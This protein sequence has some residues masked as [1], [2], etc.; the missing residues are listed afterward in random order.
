VS[1]CLALLGQFVK[2]GRLSFKIFGHT[3]LYTQWFVSRRPTK[4]SSDTKQQD[5]WLIGC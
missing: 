1:T 4:A 5:F 2:I 3:G